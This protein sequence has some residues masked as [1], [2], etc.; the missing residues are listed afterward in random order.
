MLAKPAPRLGRA[1]SV[2]FQECP[3][4]ASVT[5]EAEVRELMHD[6]RVEHERWRQQES[7]AE[8]QRATR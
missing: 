6:D 3:E 8:R 4:A 7:P 5:P 1:W 2:R